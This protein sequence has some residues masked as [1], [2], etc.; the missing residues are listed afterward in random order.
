MQ[1]YTVVLISMFGKYYIQVMEGG[2][3]YYR[4][5]P[6]VH[7]IDAVLDYHINFT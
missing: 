7:L 1:P 2:K 5:D 4:S 3:E 6:Y